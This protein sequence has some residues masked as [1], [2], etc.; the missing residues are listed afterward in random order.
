MSA[1]TRPPPSFEA[2]FL[3]PALD[4]EATLDAFVVG[5]ARRPLVT[6]SL[7]VLIVSLHLGVG[8]LDH[9]AGRVG[10]GGA[11]FYARSAESLAVAGARIS[12]AVAIGQLWR[13]VSCILL[14]VDWFHLGLNGLALF[15]LGRICEAL[16]GRAR[17]L[18]LFVVSGLG[19]ALLSQLGPASSSVGASGAIFGLMGAC[20]AFGWRFRGVLPTGLRK[21]LVRGLAPWVVLNL[22]IGFSVP[23][24]DNLGHIGGLFT[25]G[26]CALLLR[27]RVIPGEPRQNSARGGALTGL[28][29]GLLCWSLMNAGWSVQEALGAF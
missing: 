13:L 28:C 29:V 17:L 9:A 27:D 7:L 5:L 8:G 4:R 22:V 15:G 24:I 23:R 25:G 21:L 6:V 26:I 3:G 19:G 12:E 1:G 20:M 10:I 2:I 11:L 14:H 16:Y 18:T